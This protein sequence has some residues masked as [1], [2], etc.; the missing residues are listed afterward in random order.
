MTEDPDP[1]EFYW[2]FGDQTAVRTPSR[3]FI[4]KYLHPDRYNVTVSMSSSLGS[5]IS[6]V[7]TVVIQRAVHLNRLLYTRSV[8]MNTSVPFS[9]RIN[10]G[11]NITYLWDFGDGTRRVGRDTEH[12]VFNSTGEFVIE[13]TISNLVSSASLKGHV[14]VV[15]EPCQPP[16]VKNMGPSKIQVW[17]YQSVSIGVTYEGQIQCNISKGV[18][19]SWTLYGQTGLQL[20]TTGIKTNQQHLELP[21][22]L[23]HYGTYRAVAKVQVVGSIVY[24]TY[25]VLLEVMSSSPVSIISGGT[26]VFINRHNSNSNI[27]VD[28]R[29]SYDPDFP[30]NIMSYRWKCRLVNMAKTSCFSKHVPA[31]SALLIF[32]ASALNANCNLFKLTLTVQSGN[33]SSSSEMFITMRSKPT[34][35]DISL[36]SKLEEDTRFFQQ[37]ATSASPSILNQTETSR[38]NE[39]KIPLDSVVSWPRWGHSVENQNTSFLDLLSEIDSASDYEDFYSGIEEADSGVSLGRPTGPHHLDEMISHSREYEGDNLVGPV[40]LGHVV[41]EKTLLDL[42][43]ELIQPALF[44]SFTSTGISSSVITFKPM[45][46]KP[47]SLYMLEVS[48]SSEEVLQGKTQLFFSTHPAPE[49]MVCHVQPSSGFEVHTH[50]SIF[51][52]SGKEDLMYEYSF[53]VG[54]ATKKLLYRGRDY[55]HYFY[56]PSGDPHDDYKGSFKIF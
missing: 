42:H 36:P 16:P 7:Y 44:E 10:A 54:N 2:H 21:E 20:T 33:R 17:R 14:F 34:S 12:H 15:L 23:L 29:R 38:G 51:C 55:Q 52:T 37:P 32:P 41:S 45:M 56:L 26:N 46:L 28:G 27:I 22:Y 19:Y 6:D 5:V 50:F 25:S 24:S 48:A 13:V 9:C 3:T 31:S 53:S 4:T 39:I 49:G 1:L 18:H 8:L 30:D 40:I 47:K 11:T 43:R 35:L